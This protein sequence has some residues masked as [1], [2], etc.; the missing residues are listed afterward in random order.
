PGILI[1]FIL[2]ITSYF[3]LRKKGV[4]VDSSTQKI[5]IKYVGK[6]FFD[7]KWAL[8]APIIILGGIYG[9]IFTPTEAAAVAIIYAYI[10]G[11]FIHK[12]LKWKDIYGCIMETSNIMGATLYMIGLSIAFA[13]ILNLE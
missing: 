10:V 3:L 6:T 4:E 12:E 2:M 9:S 7:A 8:L 5:D 1:G 11:A 13:Y